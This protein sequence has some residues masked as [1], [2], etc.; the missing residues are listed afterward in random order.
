MFLV[1]AGGVRVVA[2]AHKRER[3]R[4]RESED[5]DVNPEVIEE[6]RYFGTRPTMASFLSSEKSSPAG[7][8]SQ[9]NFFA[10][11]G[12]SDS[13]QVTTTCVAG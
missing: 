4:E 8:T 1:S 7:I 6:L 11:Q 10:D 2:L 5:S 3:E 13:N 9:G 12:H